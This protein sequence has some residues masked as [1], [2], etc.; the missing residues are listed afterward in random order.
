LSKKE[1]ENH[2]KLKG[3][4]IQ[5]FKLMIKEKPGLD[6]YD[7]S[8]QSDAEFLKNDPIDGSFFNFILMFTVMV[9]MIL[10]LYTVSI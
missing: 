2:E 7:G 4:Y 5:I 6:T 10:S 8:I 9:L 3:D 1:T